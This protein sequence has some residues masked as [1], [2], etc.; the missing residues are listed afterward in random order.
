[1]SNEGGR[2][3]AAGDKTMDSYGTA[4]PADTYLG[5]STTG[6]VSVIDTANPAAA[7]GSIAVGLH[8]TALFVKGDALFVANAFDD[9]V[10]VVDTH[11]DRVVQT[12]ETR[13]WPSSNV[14]YEPTSI[15]MTG[16]GHLL[17]T[18]GRANAVAVY[19]Y[20]GNPQDPV[21][22]IGLV[23]TDYFPATVAT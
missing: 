13:P 15:A 10:S 11:T 6:T 14:G 17:V 20:H 5:T 22:D 12:I 19:R 18:L 4:V 8:P 1:V 23:P 16:D 9:T 3:A 21:N 7:V 2:H